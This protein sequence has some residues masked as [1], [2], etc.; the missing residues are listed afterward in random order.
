MS[1][2]VPAVR[3]GRALQLLLLAAAASTAIYARTAVGPLQEAIRVSLQLSDNQMALLQGAALALPLVIAAAPLGLIVDRYVRVRL[4][5]LFVTLSAGASILTAMASGF[6]V[7]FLARSLVGLAAAATATAVASLVADLYLPAQRGR[8]NIMVAVGQVGGM[9]AAFALGGEL[10]AM[11]GGDTQGWRWAMF[12]LSMPMLVVVAL[13]CVL[14]EPPRTGVI[15]KH[16]SSGESFAE[17]WQYRAI[18]AP[19]LSGFVMVTVADGAAL[20]WVAPTLVRTFA[21]SP[22]HVGALIAMVLLVTGIAGPI[23][24]GTLADVCQR[25]GGPRRT[26]LMLGV[27]AVLSIPAGLFALAP[28]V[29]AAIGLL[30]VFL[31]IG[32]ATSVIVTTLLTI[33]VPNELRGLCTSILWAAG[34]LFG[35]GAAPL[36]VS[37]LSG[38]IGGPSAVG[39]ALAIVCVATSAI[40]AMVFAFGRRYLPR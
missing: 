35:L 4:L 15:R 20:V 1:A 2:V 5:L 21:L 24:G 33:V 7:L 19:L 11:T 13:T 17:L 31:A 30:I 23:A 22:D 32:A 40:G 39:R 18:L 26:M 37:L 16:A 10:L 9:S 27:L 34:A 3:E 8:A 38:E 36:T 14:R 28:S 29:P 6:A 12:W 25:A